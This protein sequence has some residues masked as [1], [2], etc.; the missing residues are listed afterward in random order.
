MA[1]TGNLTLATFQ[2]FLARLGEKFITPTE[3]YLIGGS[4]LYLL[5]NQRIT[6]DIDYV[7]N[8][9]PDSKDIIQPTIQQL[10]AEMHLEVEGIPLDEL[11]PLPPD[12]HLRHRLWGQFGNLNVYSF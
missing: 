1:N 5:G 4:A 8:D 2:F 3:L 6:S 7:G 11:I 12:A 10:A 9:L